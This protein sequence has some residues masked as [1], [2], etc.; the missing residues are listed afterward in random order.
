M[1]Y[2]KMVRVHAYAPVDRVPDE[3]QRLVAQ[4]RTPEFEQAH[5]VLQTAYMHYALV[6]V[7]PFADLNGRAARSLA[8]TFLLQEQYIPL[9]VF[10]DQRDWYLDVLS[11][12]DQGDYQAFVGFIFRC[13]FQAIDHIVGWL[14]VG[15]QKA[16]RIE[17]EATEDEYR[18]LVK[19]AMALGLLPSEYM[20]AAVREYAKS[21]EAGI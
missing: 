10:A 12:A 3:M 14:S 19:H 8:S 1:S 15:E 4:L 11:A 9:V 5:P 18:E 7:H 20:R 2:S 13:A 16:V 21:Q 17:F 6:V